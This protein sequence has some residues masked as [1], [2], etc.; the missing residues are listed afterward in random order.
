M[1]NFKTILLIFFTVL[2]ITLVFYALALKR[3]SDLLRRKNFEIQKSLDE[4]Q[5]KLVEC[6]KK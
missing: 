4:T 1:K 6:E 5:S 2:T 3:E